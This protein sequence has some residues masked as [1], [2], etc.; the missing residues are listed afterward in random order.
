MH[1]LK[2]TPVFTECRQL[3]GG[4]SP[5]L[6]LKERLAERGRGVRPG[7]RLLGNYRTGVRRRAA[8]CRLGAEA[9]HRVER[10]AQDGYASV[11]SRP[12]WYPIRHFFVLWQVLFL[13]ALMRTAKR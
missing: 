9:S 10:D 11:G 3:K 6:L 13:I 5:R 8:G 2:H 1:A 12:T 7:G 4:L